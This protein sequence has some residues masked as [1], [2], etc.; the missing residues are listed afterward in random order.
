MGTV[1]AF[2][3]SGLFA[4]NPNLGWPF[5]FWVFGI[6]SGVCFCLVWWFGASTPH[7]HP[8]ISYE[9]LA[10]ITGN[11][12]AGKPKVITLNILKHHLKWHLYSANFEVFAFHIN[13]YTNE[14]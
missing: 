7:D 10:Y 3:I 9:E 12:A 8:K 11:M 5:N 6:G 4:G 13:I 2:Q 14:N 1:V